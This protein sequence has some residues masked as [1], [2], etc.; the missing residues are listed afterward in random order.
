MQRR[1][2]RVTIQ[3]TWW[4]S[5]PVPNCHGMVQLRKADNYRATD[6]CISIRRG[7]LTSTTADLDKMTAMHSRVNP[8]AKLLK[9]ATQRGRFK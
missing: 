6:A 9:T 5:D 7:V 4:F 8:E 3:K 1:Y 2:T